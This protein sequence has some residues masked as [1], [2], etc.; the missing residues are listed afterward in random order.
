MY[1]IVDYSNDDFINVI[2]DSE[3]SLTFIN[4]IDAEEYAK[5]NLQE[6]FW[7]VI[8]MDIRGTKK[9]KG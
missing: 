3:G 6:G 8:E 4:W 7:Q 5:E 2:G 1:F 9:W